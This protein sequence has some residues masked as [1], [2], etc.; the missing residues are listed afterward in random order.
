MAPKGKFVL[1][2]PGDVIFFRDV[3]RC[4]PHA[5][6]HDPVHGII[7]SV[8][9]SHISHAES[10]P[11]VAHDKMR[12]GTHALHAT[13]N[14]DLCI[15]KPDILGCDDRCLDSRGAGAVHC[16][17]IS[18]HGYSRFLGG[19][20]G[21]IHPIAGLPAVAEYRHIYILRFHTGFIQ[22]FLYDLSAE[23]IGGHL[24]QGTSKESHGAPVG[25]NHDN[26]F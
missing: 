16:L 13:G 3:F 4:E 14:N 1:V 21:G 5:D 12:D 23:I 26:I 25:S 18:V 9:D 6:A 20:P 19:G 24:P 8:H 7:P 10:V 11:A 2:L 17:G 22:G 15:P